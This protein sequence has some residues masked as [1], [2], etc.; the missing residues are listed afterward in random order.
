MKFSKE[1]KGLEVG[2]FYLLKVPKWSESGYMVAECVGYENH[3]PVFADEI[4]GRE[5]DQE[6]VEGWAPLDF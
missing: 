3:K 2:S 4:M 6:D 1:S 5:V